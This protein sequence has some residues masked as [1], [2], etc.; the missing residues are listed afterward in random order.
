MLSLE[1]K[2]YLAIIC[3]FTAVLVVTLTLSSRDAEEL[4]MDVMEDQAEAAALSYFDSLNVL[5]LSGTMASRDTLQ[6]KMLARPGVT[7]ARIIRGEPITRIFGEG[8][9]DEKVLDNYDQRALDGESILEER[10]DNGKRLLTVVHPMK[11]LSDYHGT[12][13]LQCHVEPEG[14]VLGAVRLTFSLD[15]LDKELSSS[16]WRQGLSLALLFVVG[17]VSLA[18]LVRRL[19]IRRVKRLRDTIRRIEMDSD[20]TTRLPVQY[21]DEIGA[22]NQAFNAML[23]KF[24]SSLHEVVDTAHHLGT[25]TR[26]IS[27]NAS[28]TAKAV[29]EQQ[30]GTDMMASAIHEMEATSQDFRSN[31]EQTAVASEEADKA[32]H[33]GEQTNQRVIDAINGLSQEIRQASSV[34]ANLDGRTQSV[35]SVLS[36]IKGIAEQTN[37]LALNAAIEAAR[38]GE[39]GRGFAVVAD[40]VR[41][42]ATRTQESAAEIERMIS[43][44]KQE[45]EDA[46]EVMARANS[47]AERS[48][49]QVGEASELLKTITE[50]VSGINQ[51]N[52]NMRSVADDQSSAA[53]EINQTVLRIA[54]IAEQSAG[55]AS[56]TANLTIKLEELASR[57]N[58]LVERFRIT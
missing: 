56:A 15:E 28:S 57:L 6:K 5:M 25:A 21:E 24:Q 40:E 9:S 3:C 4:V 8:R 16:L 13:C 46:V 45:A 7:E 27:V 34:I 50:R 2:I 36:V 44:L 32:A 54:Q 38:A 51:L 41:A 17:L 12:N 11:A 33:Q 35:A 18:F 31:A 20:L 49:A 19:V 47:A 43:E 22:T 1:N 30:N 53:A 39:S 52:A 37:L 48:V 23:A 26:Q 14:T 58:E 29:Q 10:M 55:D 42:L